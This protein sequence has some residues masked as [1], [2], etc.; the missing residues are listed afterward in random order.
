M[1]CWIKWGGLLVFRI[2][3]AITV[4]FNVKA[5]HNTD[6]NFRPNTTQIQIHKLSLFALMLSSCRDYW[7]FGP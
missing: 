4:L 3:E 2:L 7:D 1:A 5:A 6:L